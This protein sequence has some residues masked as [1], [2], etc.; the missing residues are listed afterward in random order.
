MADI[1][2]CFIHCVI[3]NWLLQL[4]LLL[5]IHHYYSK[6]P[7]HCTHYT[8]THNNNHAQYNNNNQRPR[9]LL[10]SILLSWPLHWA[11]ASCIISSVTILLICCCKS[12]EISLEY[13]Q[14]TTG[15]HQSET[16]GLLLLNPLSYTYL[17]PFTKSYCILTNCYFQRDEILFRGQ[18]E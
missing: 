1:T 8:N 13:C 16:N 4:I 14:K 18:M 6:I 3:S 10:R 11:N 17:I 2:W 15:K 9:V 7:L 12:S 5:P